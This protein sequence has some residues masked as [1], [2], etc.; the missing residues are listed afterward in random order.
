MIERIVHKLLLNIAPE[1]AHHLSIFLLRFVPIR[2]KKAKIKSLRLRVFDRYFPHPLGLAAGF[3]KDA[4]A[5]SSLSKLGFS[6]VEIGSVTPIPQPGNSK[7]RLFRL[8]E[9]RAIVNRYGFNSKGIGYVEKRL[10][11]RSRDDFIG[12]NLGKNKNTT[13]DMQDFIIGV[14]KLIDYADYITINLSSPN[15]PGLRDLQN[16]DVL[17]PFIKEIDVIRS[18]RNKKCKILIKLSPDMDIVQECKLL[19]YLSTSQVDGLIVSNTTTDRTMLDKV[20][21]HLINGGLS[22]EPLKLK[23]REMLKRTYEIVGKKKVIVSSGGIDSGYEAYLRIC[24]GASLC[25]IYSAL[26]Y[27]GPSI[28]DKFNQ[29]IESFMIKDGFSTLEEARGSYY[30]K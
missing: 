1:K 12:V 6:F 26:I 13:N 28:I 22:G 9:N 29:E 19:R 4:Q 14:E 20:P 7:P 15:T 18:I 30:A 10:V 8:K 27:E 24:M 23:S 5:Y 2:K 11:G 21:D 17:E 25:Q 3:D 16:I